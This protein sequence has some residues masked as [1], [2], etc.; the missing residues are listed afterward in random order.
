MAIRQLRRLLGIL[1]IHLSSAIESAITPGSGDEMTGEYNPEYDSNVPQDRRDLVKVRE[2]RKIL[3]G[4]LPKTSPGRALA[5]RT[6][7]KSPRRPKP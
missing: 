6:K 4:N 2:W 3:S 5:S 7:T 1:D